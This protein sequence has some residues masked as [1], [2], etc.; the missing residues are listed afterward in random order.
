[1]YYS[2]CTIIILY[3]YNI[4]LYLQTI[5]ITV[6]V[7]PYIYI[8]HFFFYR[9]EYDDVQGYRRVLD[10]ILETDPFLRPECIR[11]GK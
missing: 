1:M 8:F 4:D 6:I 11:S 10:D 7:M 9:E 5:T 3:H 2:N